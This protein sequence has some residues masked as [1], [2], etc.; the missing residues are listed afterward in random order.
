[1]QDDP[2]P[3]FQKASFGKPKPAANGAMSAEEAE[4]I[5]LSGLVFLTSDEPR[6]TRFL[7]DTGLTPHG[8][9]AA[10]GQRETLAAVL[11]HLLSDES[12]LLVF[13]SDSAIEP[14]AVAPA[15]MKLVA[16]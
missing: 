3:S 7:V 9:A 14:A 8:L 16:G 13:A 5:G 15:H 2:M 10:A 12:L 1:M 6:L 11:D 4:R